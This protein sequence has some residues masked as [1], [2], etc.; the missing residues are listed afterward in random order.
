M[1]SHHQDQHP[2]KG[3]LLPLGER[4]VSWHFPLEFWSDWLGDKQ[5]DSLPHFQLHGCC[6]S[7][8]WE[9]RTELKSKVLSLLG[10][11]QLDMRSWKEDHSIIFFMEKNEHHSMKTWSS[12]CKEDHH[13]KLWMSSDTDILIEV[14]DEVGFSVTNRRTNKLNLLC[15]LGMEDLRPVS[16]CLFPGSDCYASVLVLFYKMRCKVKFKTIV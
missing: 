10:Q 6:F 1:Q 11:P 3:R 16:G 13:I 4:S 2:P 12:S 14:F 9:E 5:I 7:L 8:L 15:I